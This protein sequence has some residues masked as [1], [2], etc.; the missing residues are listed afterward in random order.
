MSSAGCPLDV[1]KTTLDQKVNILKYAAETRKFEIERYWQRSLFFW[2]F[3]GAAFVSYAALY[4]KTD[5]L[6]PLVIACFG[7][8][9]SVAWTLQNRGSKYWQEAWE[10]KVIAVE[11]DV[12]GASLF[13]NS[14][15]IQK[16]GIWGAS[17][18]SVSK[19]AVAL[20][21]FTVIIWVVL[22]IK[23]FPAVSVKTFLTPSDFALIFIVFTVVYIV[24]L[25]VF[26]R[27]KRPTA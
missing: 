1:S 12:L 4:D 17:K 6:L 20:S 21:D 27:S 3:I 10:Q 18:Y 8:V 7:L 9:C 15:P 24:L 2:G 5:K 11:R 26:G 13:S 22:M 19:L 14:E 25:F 23:A 16:K